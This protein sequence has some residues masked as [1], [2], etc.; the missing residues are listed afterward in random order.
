[1]EI[2]WPIKVNLF[3]GDPVAYPRSISFVDVTNN[4]PCLV[5]EAFRCLASSFFLLFLSPSG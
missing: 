5:G 4:E 1:M 2:L 3:C